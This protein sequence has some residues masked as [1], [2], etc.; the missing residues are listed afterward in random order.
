M[1]RRRNWGGEFK[2]VAILVAIA[3]NKDEYLEALGATEVIKEGE[4]NW[5]SFFQRLRGRGLDEVKFSIVPNGYRE[6][7]LLKK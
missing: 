2:N 7:Y 6:D 4:S 5:V 1:F 3:V